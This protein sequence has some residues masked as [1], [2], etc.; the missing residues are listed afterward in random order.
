M[1]KKESADGV[2]EPDF[3]PIPKGMSARV[4]LDFAEIAKKE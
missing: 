3:L 2:F 4:A 1:V